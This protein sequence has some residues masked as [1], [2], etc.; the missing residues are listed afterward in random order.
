MDRLNVTNPFDG[1]PVGEIMLSSQRDVETALATAAKTHQANRKGLP[2]NERI[3]VL[4]KAAEI[5]F[6]NAE[7][8]RRAETPLFK[9]M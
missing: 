8:L 7:I 2:K 9:S 4:K 5:R 3:A 1:S 6:S